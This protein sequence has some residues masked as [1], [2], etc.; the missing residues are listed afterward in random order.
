MMKPDTTPCISVKQPWAALIMAG[1]KAVENRS[2]PSKHLG[3]LLI[4]AS[5]SYDAEGNWPF[6]AALLY[7]EPI[8]SYRITKRSSIQG[9]I[10][11]H[12]N[13]I[14]CSK[15]HG[16]SAWHKEGMWGY[17]FGLEPSSI[18]IFAEPIPYRGQ[19]GIYGVPNEIL[20]AEGL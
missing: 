14:G 3:R 12:V 17:Y 13:M 6:V 1:I 20:P 8:E 11:G 4:H 16:L 19:L 7:R 2:K 10:I 15:Q 5:K 9:A 18:K